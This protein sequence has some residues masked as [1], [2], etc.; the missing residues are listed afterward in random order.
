MRYRITLGDWSGDGHGKTKIFDV[1]VNGATLEQL[2]ENYLLNIDKI[3]FDPQRICE[4]YEDATW[5]SDVI[6]WL[7][8]VGFKF[9]EY[10]DRYEEYSD[11][12]LDLEV[13]ADMLMFFTTRGL[14]GV[15]YK[16]VK[17]EDLFG[18]SAGGSYGYAYFH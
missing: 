5:P 16:F 14:D 3:G 18:E 11:E 7:E 8:V 9:P 10:Y 13:Y 12:A 15:E 17:T 2:K 4:D 1:E 6:D